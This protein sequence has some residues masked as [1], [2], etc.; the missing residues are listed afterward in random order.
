MRGMTDYEIEKM[1][2]YAAPPVTTG[3]ADRDYALGLG[4]ECPE[5][6]WILSDRD[7]WYANPF[8]HGPKVPHPEEDYGDE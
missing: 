8:Y 4:A 6:P 2:H 5:R 7:V 1:E 3:Q